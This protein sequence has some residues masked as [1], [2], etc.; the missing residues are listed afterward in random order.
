MREQ[1]RVAAA[2]VQRLYGCIAAVGGFGLVVTLW[3]SG[4]SQLFVLLMAAPAVALFG[5]WLVL[6][7]IKVMPR[8]PPDASFGQR[9]HA[10]P[11]EWRF[12]ICFIAVVSALVGLIT[13]YR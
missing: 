1:R 4:E 10:M 9:L 13:A 8:L 2:W 7:P 12:G 6:F 5:L 3:R 11:P